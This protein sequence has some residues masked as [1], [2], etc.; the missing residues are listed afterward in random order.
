MYEDL[1]KPPSIPALNLA[2]PLPK[3]NP[4]AWTYERLGKYIKDFEAELDSD[5]EIG[6]RFVSFGQTVIFHIESV[7]YYGPDIITFHGRNDAMEKVQL[8]QH[9][10]QL[11]V[12]LVAMKKQ[13]EKPRRIGFLWEKE[14]PKSNA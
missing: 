8:I 14:E 11:S 9:V 4:A 5:H 3:A 1:I 13:Q 6:A 10:S 2:P 12:L 7:G